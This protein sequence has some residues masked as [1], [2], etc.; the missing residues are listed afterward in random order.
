MAEIVHNDDE[1]A[2]SS[3]DTSEPLAVR[4]LITTIAGRPKWLAVWPKHTTGDIS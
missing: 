2:W 1:I 4:R 3:D